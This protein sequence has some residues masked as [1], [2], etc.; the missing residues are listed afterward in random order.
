[1]NDAQRR[2]VADVLDAAEIV[3]SRLRGS[4]M[5]S[6]LVAALR[7]EESTAQLRKAFEGVE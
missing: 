6:D 3:L 4:R 7:L 1:M 2:A 5:E